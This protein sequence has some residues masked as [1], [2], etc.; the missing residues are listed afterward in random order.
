MKP[1][2]RAEITKQLTYSPLRR[3]LSHFVDA[4]YR[5]AKPLLYSKIKMLR[6]AVYFTTKANL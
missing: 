1:Q 3:K 6:C 5:Q 2:H 4:P